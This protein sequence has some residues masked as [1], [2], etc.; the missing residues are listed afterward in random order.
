MPPHLWREASDHALSCLRARGSRTRCELDDFSVDLQLRRYEIKSKL[1]SH[2]LIFPWLHVKPRRHR[3]TLEDGFIDTVIEA[4]NFFLAEKPFPEVDLEFFR[5]LYQEMES[6]IPIPSTCLTD[7]VHVYQMFLIHRMEIEEAAAAHP[8]LSPAGS[9]D[10]AGL[11]SPSPS[12]EIDDE[13]HSPSECDF[14]YGTFSWE[15]VPLERQEVLPDLDE[16]Q[17]LDH[18]ATRSDLLPALHSLR[19][20]IEKQLEKM[21]SSS[22]TS[23][24]SRT[25]PSSPPPLPALFIVHYLVSWRAN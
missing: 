23:K 13:S 12:P 10:V 1:L 14:F 15:P 3:Q 11:L 4:I 25:G 6:R 9:I 8:P 19:S 20:D 21:G 5:K 24:R 2:L 16:E 22:L 7:I 17:V 18:E